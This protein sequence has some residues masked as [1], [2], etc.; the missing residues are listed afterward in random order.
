MDNHIIPDKLITLLH[1]ELL[2][3][4]KDIEEVE[5]IAQSNVIY[6]AFGDKCPKNPRK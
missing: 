1:R 3:R 4:K 6:I 5:K 2:Q